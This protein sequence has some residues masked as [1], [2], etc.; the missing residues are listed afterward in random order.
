MSATIIQTEQCD[1][2]IQDAV[3]KKHTQ[4]A[5]DNFNG[6]SEL[7]AVVGGDFLAVY[8]VS[9]T[10][11]KK[12]QRSNFLQHPH[13][14]AWNSSFAY[15]L[16]ADEPLGW[17]KIGSP[18]AIAQDT[19]IED[20]YNDNHALKVTSGGSSNEGVSQTLKG[21][22]KS[23]KYTVRLWMKATSGDTAKAWTTGGSSDLSITSTSTSGEYVSGTFTTD[24]S[25]T[26]VVL[27]LGSETSGDIVYFDCLVVAEG[28]GIPPWYYKDAVFD[29]PIP[30]H[31]PAGDGSET[32]SAEAIPGFYMAERDYEIVGWRIALDKAATVTMDVWKDVD[33]NY[34]PTNADTITASAKPAT[35]SAAKTQSTTLTGWTVAISKGDWIGAEIEANDAATVIDFFLIIRRR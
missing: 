16:D 19:G 32:V 21:L 24:S 23:T 13:N 4:A 34:P 28:D 12:V 30:L 6:L 35:S 11:Y 3:S 10:G 29:E 27:K 7:A 5:D 17:P 18:T 1:S 33:A 25:A 8:D 20:G 14:L 22:K 9:A 15:F 2:D 31:F 26:D